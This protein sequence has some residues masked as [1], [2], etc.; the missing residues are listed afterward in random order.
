[1]PLSVQR[2][3]SE[4]MLDHLVR[5]G[6]EEVEYHVL[7]FDDGPMVDAFRQA[8]VSV[9]VLDAGRLRDPLRFVRTVLRIRRYAAAWGADAVLSWAAKPH[10][11]ASPAAAS[12]GVPALWYQLGDPSQFHL[13]DRVATALPT[14][15]VLACSAEMA[16][17][18]R[19]LR[20]TRPTRVVYPSVDLGRFDPDALLSPAEARRTLGLPEAGPLVGIVGRLQRWKGM[21]TLVE[22]MPAVLE[23]HPD[24]HAVVVGGRHDF[25]PD[26]EDV[27]RAQVAALGLQDRFHIAGYQADVPLWMQAFDVV[28]HASDREPFGIVVIEAMALAKP[29]VVGA[30]G[31][32]AEI[33]TPGVDGLLAGFED[34][35]A[36]AAA[37]DRFLSDPDGAARMATAARARALEFS[38]ERF[39]RTV[40]D[41]VHEVAGPRAA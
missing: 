39:A 34:A 5:F 19:A 38:P 23:R 1:M 4:V 26:Y 13:L 9:S 10:L 15:A 3:G 24:V 31:G 16:R 20:P 28:V 8:G 41:A 35:P 40:A 36:L 18:Q 29:V 25:E 12:L 33:V 6:G 30:E 21:H 11:Y 7:F 2:G 14:A 32:P 17:A 22:A 27:L 37:L